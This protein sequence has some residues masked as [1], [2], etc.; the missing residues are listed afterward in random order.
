VVAPLSRILKRRSKSSSNS[1][2]D[3]DREASLDQ[4]ES[5]PTRSGA[6]RVEVALKTDI[7]SICWARSESNRSSRLSMNPSRLLLGVN[8]EASGSLELAS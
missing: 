5:D 1:G 6:S 8:E 4:F 3:L 2:R 7:F